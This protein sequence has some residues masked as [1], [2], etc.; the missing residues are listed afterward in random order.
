MERLRTGTGG[1]TP[2]LPMTAGINLGIIDQVGFGDQV[3]AL[4][5]RLLTTA[6]E[7]MAPAPM[8]VVP[9]TREAKPAL[10]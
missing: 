6:V 3:T 1:G 7:Q 10:D 8:Y 2:T 4:L 9:V 5:W